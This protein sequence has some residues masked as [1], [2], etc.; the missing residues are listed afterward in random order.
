MDGWLGAASAPAGMPRAS[1][2]ENPTSILHV[3]VSVPIPVA[4]QQTGTLSPVSCLRKVN[5]VN[6]MEPTSDSLTMSPYEAKVWEALNAHW[7]QRDNR[8]GLP[9]WADKAVKRTGQSLSN[10][11]EKLSEAIPERVKEKAGE[12][13]KAVASATLRPTA[14]ALLSLLTLLDDWAMELN[15]PKTVEKIAAKKGIQIGSYRDPERFDVAVRGCFGRRGHGSTVSRP[16][17]G[18]TGV[19]KCRHPRDPDP[20]CFDRQQSGVFIWI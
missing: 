14:E 18:H 8:R 5:H 10:T 3:I 20:Q 1:D 11:A 12:A 16:L 7:A 17:R 2:I 15:D 4:F 19:Y 13:G 6:G 9:N